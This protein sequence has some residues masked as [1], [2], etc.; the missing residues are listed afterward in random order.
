L[1]TNVTV[2]RIKLNSTLTFIFKKH[3]IQTDRMNR[4]RFS[5]FDYQSFHI[6]KLDSFE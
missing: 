2:K 1:R 4:L 5:T 3:M 6:I